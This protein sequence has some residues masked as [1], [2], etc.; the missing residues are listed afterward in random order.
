MVSQNTQ[1]IQGPEMEWTEDA[2]LHKWFKDWKEEAELLLSTVLLYIRNL[3][4]KLKFVSLWTGKEA[5]TYLST[6][7]K[8][9]R[10]SLN[11]TYENYQGYKPN[12]KTLVLF[13]IHLIHQSHP[14][15]DVMVN[16]KMY[17]L[18]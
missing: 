6:V 3:E 7:D 4:T 15:L 12:K 13:Q 2:D 18:A 14:C 10:E 17:D 9:K 5:R 8:D 16:F 1:Y 11:V